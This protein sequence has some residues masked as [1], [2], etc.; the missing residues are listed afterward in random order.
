MANYSLDDVE[1]A[2]VEH[3]DTF[4]I[5][6]IE[7]RER[8]RPGDLVKLHFRG[9]DSDGEETV[10]RMW[11][12]VANVSNTGYV[13]R[14][15]NDPV[16]LVGINGDEIVSFLPNHVSSIWIETDHDWEHRITQPP[17]EFE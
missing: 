8:L 14:L 1:L 3:P 4:G 6:S 13:G 7:M 9:W 16:R 15:D 10:E 5:P 17:N 11:V 2:A 12:G